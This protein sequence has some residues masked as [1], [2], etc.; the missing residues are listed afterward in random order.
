MPKIRVLAI[1]SDQFGVGKFRI[2]DPFKYISD[3]YSDE[4]H[5]DISLDV[6]NNDDFFR[7][8]DIVYFHSFIHKLSHQH[9]VNRLKWLKENGIKTIMDIDDLWFVDQRH[10]LYYAIKAGNVAEKR[11]ELLKSSDYVATTTPIFAE[12]IKQ[13]LNIKNIIIFPNAVNDEEPQFQPNKISSEKIRFGWLGGSSHLA[14]IELLESGISTI[15]NQFKDKIQFVLCGFDTRGT[16]TEYNKETGEERQRPIQ[17]LETVWF[18]YESIFTDKYRVLDMDYKTYLFNFVESPYND[19]DKPYVR[20]WTRNI[21]TYA[22]NYNYFDVS[23]APL[24]ESLFNESKSQL[25]VIEAGFHKKALI[26]SEVKPY[27]LDLISGISEGK[28]NGKGNSLLVSPKKNHKQWA[29]HMKK[30]IEN[31]NMIEDLGNRLYE[32]VKDK[33]SLKNVSKDRIQFFKSIINN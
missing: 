25:K 13:R 29:Q 1:P 21:D 16:V 11:V 30:L 3:N 23:L 14:D 9:N 20:R 7:N 28:F 18:K 2:L 24:V 8:Y 15:H 27:T 26:A 33:Y 19:L 4:I 6:P 22:S 10:P 12:T 32:T 17:P 31:P 5:V